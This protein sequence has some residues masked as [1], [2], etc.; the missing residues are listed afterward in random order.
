MT[1]RLP[2]GAVREMAV[3][4]ITKKYLKNIH[5]T[6]SLLNECFFFR[7]SSC[8]NLEFFWKGYQ[9]CLCWSDSL[10]EAHYLNEKFCNTDFNNLL[11]FFFHYEQEA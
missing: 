7:D 2:L 9:K 10:K 1:Q 5:Q 11:M 6:S 3:L 4:S 8:N